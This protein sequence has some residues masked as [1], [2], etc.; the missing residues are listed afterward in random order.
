MSIFEMGTNFSQSEEHQS[1]IT[2]VREID[3]TFLSTWIVSIET[4]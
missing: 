2:K 1:L 3:L 4:G